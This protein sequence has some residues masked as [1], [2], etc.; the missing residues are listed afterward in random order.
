M[1]FQDAE[2][3]AKDIVVN[4]E[5]LKFPGELLPEA[6]MISELSKLRDFD[7]GPQTCLTPS[8]VHLKSIS[9]VQGMQMNFLP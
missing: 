7:E 3:A 4:G 6:I 9:V 8:F 1:P 5:K 2:L